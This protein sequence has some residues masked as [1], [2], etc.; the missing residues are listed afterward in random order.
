MVI[1]GVNRRT[2]AVLALAALGLAGISARAHAVIINVD[3]TSNNFSSNPVVVALDAGT[4]RVSLV[5]GLYQAW[6]AWSATNCAVATGCSQNA[7]F[8]GWLNTFVVANA[9]ISSVVF[10]GI[11]QFLPGTGFLVNALIG[12]DNT[13]YPTPAQALAAAGY[14][15]FVLDV[16]GNVNFGIGDNT[17][18]DNRGGLSLRITSVP[19]PASLALLGLGLTGLFFGSRRRSRST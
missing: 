17:L 18:T 12:G 19:E 1:P 4:Y 6:S 11:G 10:S 14:A 15:T 13:V 16:A 5:D 7:G 2:A 9:N 3:A 8:T